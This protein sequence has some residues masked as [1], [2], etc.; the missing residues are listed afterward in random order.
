[1]LWSNAVNSVPVVVL[2]NSL[3]M[4]MIALLL[5]SSPFERARELALRQRQV[6]R[7]V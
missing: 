3:T 6:M 1:M 5:S 4:S 7:L 2:L